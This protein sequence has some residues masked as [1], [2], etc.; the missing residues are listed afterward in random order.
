[1]NG[2]P[3]SESAEKGRIHTGAIAALQP[4]LPDRFRPQG[5]AKNAA[6]GAAAAGAAR[7]PLF[8]PTL[9]VERRRL[10]LLFKDFLIFV[11]DFLRARDRLQEASRN[12]TIPEEYKKILEQQK[13]APSLEDDDWL[14]PKKK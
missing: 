7:L 10:T 2:L 6:W 8:A 1:M 14:T 5:K 13:Q 3:T 11:R 12:E 9:V 4:R